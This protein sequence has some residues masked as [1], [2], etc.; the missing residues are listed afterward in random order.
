M[1]FLCDIAYLAN[2]FNHLNDVNLSIQGQ[3]LTTTDVIERLQAFY[4]KLPIWEKRLE[5]DNFGDFPMLEEV[6]L[7]AELIIPK[8]WFPSC[9]E[10]CAK[11][12]IDCSSL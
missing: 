11:I 12:W 1:K 7:K 4:A 8:P 6:I 2:I 5:T 3:D 10:I 9:A